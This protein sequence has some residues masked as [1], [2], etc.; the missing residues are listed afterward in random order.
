MGRC[1]STL[2]RT[3]PLTCSTIALP[4]P[5]SVG[6]T[7][8]RRRDHRR[9][10]SGCVRRWRT[11]G[12]TGCEPVGGLCPSPTSTLGGGGRVLTQ[13]SDVMESPRSQTQLDVVMR[14]TR[15]GR[16]MRC[17]G[18]P[19]RGSTRD[20]HIRT[21]QHL[22][23][24]SEEASKRS[25]AFDSVAGSA[26]IPVHALN[27][28]HSTCCACISRRACRPR[29]A[30]LF[31]SNSCSNPGQTLAFPGTDRGSG[32]ALASSAGTLWR[33]LAGLVTDSPLPQTFCTLA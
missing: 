6:C 15:Q 27:T 21:P 20:C 14:R 5:W 19:T 28:R 2:K 4:R 24:H 16:P 30:C 33:Y 18:S 22:V 23:D 32:S 12:R 25:S 9:R 29:R 11:P 26:S 8:T 1:C 17:G 31:C 13:P 3:G 7:H 10:S